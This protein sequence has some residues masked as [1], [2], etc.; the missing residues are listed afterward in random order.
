MVLGLYYLLPPRFQ[1][2]V[3]IGASVLFICSW[4]WSYCLLAGA[5]ALIG[6]WA[7]RGIAR[8]RTARGR[9][10]LLGAAT[11]FFLLVLV[12]FKWAA[13]SG[14][15][16]S[17]SEPLDGGMSLVIPL[18]V[19]FYLLQIISYL[20]D[21]TRGATFE[22]PSFREFLLYTLYFPK[23]LQGPLEKSAVFLREIR[24]PR[25]FLTI[26]RVESAHLISLALLKRFT[27]VNS[28]SPIFI[29]GLKGGGISGDTGL[30]M[31]AEL[32]L[33]GYVLHYM[34]FSSYVDLV[35][36]ISGLFG[37]SLSPNFRQPFL[38]RSPMDLWQRW[39]ISLT[40]WIGDYLY[41]P[42][43]LRTRSVLISVIA[44]FAVIGA[45]HELSW[46]W[47]VWTLYWSSLVLLHMF[48]RRYLVPRLRFL[49]SSSWTM[50]G[51]QRGLVF[52]MVCYS[53]LFTALHSASDLLTLSSR[54]FSP[55]VGWSSLRELP[56]MTL[57]SVLCLTGL[58]LFQESSRASRFRWIFYFG[59]ICLAVFLG[60][61]ESYP[62]QYLNF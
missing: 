59:N 12:F 14:L 32:G 8:A 19:S 4:H 16:V 62:F 55:Q 45:L 6:H 35:R 29:S 50:I 9:T 11:G 44:M 36:G 2:A 48:Y 39:H 49:A 24:S 17:H 31:W 60:T 56:P 53:S 37:I 52:L 7:G 34:E 3:L 58:V 18:G 1:N 23:F 21:L 54:L 57:L 43:L 28:L 5:L 38:A 40:R 10:F 41:L 20:V 13:W 15:S 33:C 47:G 30:W 22:R 46:T 26:D 51:F 61:F 25:D 27:I 42:L